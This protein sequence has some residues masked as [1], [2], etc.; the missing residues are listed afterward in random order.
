MSPVV[1]A[2]QVMIACESPTR[3]N[4]RVAAA[5][6]TGSPADWG[7]TIGGVPTCQLG[8]WTEP[9]EEPPHL[10]TALQTW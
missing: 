7:E 6:P 8:A 4:G 9:A 2:W 3:R 1:I 10:V 5:R